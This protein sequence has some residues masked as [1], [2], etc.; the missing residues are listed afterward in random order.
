MNPGII[1]ANNTSSFFIQ[2]K[3]KF[4]LNVKFQFQNMDFNVLKILSD[5]RHIHLP[6]FHFLYE[7]KNQLCA[8]KKHEVKLLNTSRVFWQS[9]ILH[10]AQQE[11]YLFFSFLNSPIFDEYTNARAAPIRMR[12]SNSYYIKQNRNCTLKVASHNNN[13]ENNGYLMA[14]L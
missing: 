13:I 7:W 12:D 10:T 14:T 9:L 5:I 6:Y 3:F 1:S 4:K 2:K 11:S 8:V